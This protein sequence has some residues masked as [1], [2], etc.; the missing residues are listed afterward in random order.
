MATEFLRLYN[1]MCKGDRKVIDTGPSKKSPKKKKEEGNGSKINTDIFGGYSNTRMSV[2]TRLGVEGMG[3]EKFI[4]TMPNPHHGKAARRQAAV[5]AKKP[6]EESKSAADAQSGRD[7]ADARKKFNDL[8]VETERI[9]KVAKEIQQQLVKGE[10]ISN[11]LVM[12]LA[13]EKKKRVGVQ[14]AKKL[15]PLTV[16]ENFPRELSVIKRDFSK[17]KWTVE[18]RDRMNSLFHE[19]ERPSANQLGAWGQYYK[20]FADRF[21]STMPGRSE[22]DVIQKLQCM[23]LKRQMHNDKEKQFWG[24]GIMIGS[25]A[26]MGAVLVSSLLSIIFFTRS[27]SSYL[28]LS[29]F[30]KQKATTSPDPKQRLLRR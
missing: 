11:N 30:M 24:E 20:G 8:M 12:R 10:N 1:E 29:Q 3:E 14:K 19:I 9:N 28:I 22:A 23:I 27:H 25:F 26:F 15:P 5:M 6:K 16:K 18:E 13:N 4:R 21:R 17:N 7:K 2:M